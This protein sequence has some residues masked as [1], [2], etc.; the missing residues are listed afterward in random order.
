MSNNEKIN[1]TTESVADRLL[2]L[3]EKQSKIGK[4]N[5]RRAKNH[6]RRVKSLLFDWTGEEFRRR[7][8]E[9]RDA[10]VIDRESTADVIC[11]RRNIHFSIEAKCGKIVS[12]DGILASPL[13]N[14]FSSWWH[15]TAY[16]ASLLSEALKRTIYPMLF[17]KPHPNF[18]W[19]ALPKIAFKT[20]LRPH[21]SLNIDNEIYDT[22]T[23]LWFPTIS[24]NV[25]HLGD[26]SC[27]VIHTKKKTNQKF[28]PL[29]LPECYLMR[30]RD[31]MAN[32][33]PQSFF[34]D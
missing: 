20:I 22:N 21:P 30:W 17:F 23:S 11:V 33:D 6:E 31:L 5:V 26:V 4:S 19:V 3:K 7:R 15:Q 25:F 9:G 28:I 12:M 2:T 8:V 24:L 29:R 32:V 27:N 10:T 16:D 14:D 1:D 34:A 18:D 13:K